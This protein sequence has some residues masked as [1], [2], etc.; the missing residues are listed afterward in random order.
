MTG[1]MLAISIAQSDASKQV[2]N[3]LEGKT[4]GKD[5]EETINKIIQ[6]YKIVVDSSIL[7]N[8]DLVGKE[9]NLEILGEQNKKI[10][11]KVVV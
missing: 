11:M 1:Q 2:W 3:Y 4:D 7:G 6:H 9:T 5:I 8:K 10:E